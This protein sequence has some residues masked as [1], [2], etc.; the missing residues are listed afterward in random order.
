M[1]QPVTVPTD[2]VDNSNV[3]EFF[4]N[5]EGGESESKSVDW[6]QR[7]TGN[8]KP[9][10]AGPVDESKTPVESDS[11]AV[12]ESEQDDGEEAT[13][14]DEGAP[15]EAGAEPGDPPADESAPAS[16]SSDD[17]ASVERLERQLE[18][19]GQQLREA[20][21]RLEQQSA[22]AQ[23]VPEPAPKRWEQMS[24]T[25]QEQMLQK[26]DAE[27]MS[28]EEYLLDQR[29][30]WKAREILRER[31]QQILQGQLQQRKTE[32][33]Q[34]I[35]SL[36]AHADSFDDHRDHVLEQ[37]NA[38][39]ELYEFLRST[40]PEVMGR[41]GK[42]VLDGF[43]ASARL[44]TL[45]AREGAVVDAARKAGREEA[46]AGK[47]SKTASSRTQTARVNTVSPNLQPAAPQTTKSFIQQLAASRPSGTWE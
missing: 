11:P 23:S 4:S 47:T 32:W 38:I 6:F 29:L 26:A 17:K 12:V 22:A 8:E 33:N 46:H 45:Q 36:E 34:A 10:R 3:A 41:V 9:E 1:S 37:F 15:A 2:P 43:A 24:R 27:G 21:W 20:Q 13:P 30:E 31:D 40:S 7:M 14:G 16:Q 18:L 5:A 44:K 35:R 25:E 39:P 28:L 42:A 19:V